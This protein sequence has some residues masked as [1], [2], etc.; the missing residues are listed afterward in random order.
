MGAV[1]E[2]F[3]RSGEAVLTISFSSVDDCTMFKVVKVD[4]YICQ[5]ADPTSPSPSEVLSKYFG[6]PVHL[7]MKGPKNRG[8]GTTQTFPDLTANALFQDRFPL[9]VASDESTEKVGDEI[10][11]WASGEVN[12][13][14]IGGI[15]DLWKTSRLPI[16]RYVCVNVR[17]P[18]ADYLNLVCG[19]IDFDQISCSVVPVCPF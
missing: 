1:G 6:R 14:R 7:V 12:G 17:V 15:D 16:E 11:Q 10:N 5:A 13:Q 8:C 9:L 3:N 18:P 2:C 4:G 19:Y